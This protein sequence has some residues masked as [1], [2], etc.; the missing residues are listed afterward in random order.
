MQDRHGVTVL[1]QQ[2]A[3]LNEK[4]CA[5]IAAVEKRFLDGQLDSIDHRSLMVVKVLVSVFSMA[6]AQLN[7]VMKSVAPEEAEWPTVESLQADLAK[8]KSD[9]YEA[10]QNLK[11]DELPES[12]RLQ[13]EDNRDR[14]RQ[15]ILMLESKIAQMKS[16]V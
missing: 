1:A 11:D 6:D 14:L 4:L 16:V 7:N 15:L 2:A 12:I 10:S 9:F 3:D 5:V 13:V 8:A